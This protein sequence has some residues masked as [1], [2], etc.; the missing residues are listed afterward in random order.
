VVVA[1]TPQSAY[2]PEPDFLE[3]VV[4][5]IPSFRHAKN[6]PEKWPPI[7]IHEFT[8]PVRVAPSP[9]FQPFVVVQVLHIERIPDSP[10]F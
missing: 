6:K 9:P 5:I 8:E 1:V 4:G 7:V 2:G 3:Y 10:A